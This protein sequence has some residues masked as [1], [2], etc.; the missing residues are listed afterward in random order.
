MEKEELAEA[1]DLTR[2]INEANDEANDEAIFTKISEELESLK[3]KEF[4]YYD[5]GSFNASTLLHQPWLGER[6]QLIFPKMGILFYALRF[7]T[8]D[9]NYLRWLLSK[10]PKEHYEEI[11][12]LI[13]YGAKYGNLISLNLLLEKFS[14]DIVKTRYDLEKFINTTL[15]ALK[16]LMLFSKDKEL[17]DEWLNSTSNFI[18]AI[19]RKI[20][21]KYD[22]DY[23][24]QLFGVIETAIDLKFIKVISV[25]RRE[26]EFR[27]YEGKVCNKLAKL[28]LEILEK[29]QDLLFSEKDDFHYFFNSAYHDDNLESFKFFAQKLKLEDY[30]GNTIENNIKERFTKFSRNPELKPIAIGVGYMFCD[31]LGRRPPRILDYLSKFPEFIQCAIDEG[32][33]TKIKGKNYWITPCYF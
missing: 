22:W 21:S 29:H 25:I 30:K 27:D 26:R 14:L 24:I 6:G 32:R 1:K 19:I 11:P 3:Y 28:P 8:G 9:A 2:R 17:T 4:L 31:V 33:I 5:N 23:K 13:S 7:S 12:V 20:D 10:I 15:Y 18:I 16:Q